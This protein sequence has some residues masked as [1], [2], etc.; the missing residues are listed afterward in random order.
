MAAGLLLAV[1]A[2]FMLPM[3]V[4]ESCTLATRDGFVRD[5]Y[6]LEFFSQGRGPHSST[7]I[8]GHLVSTGERYVTQRVHIVGLKRLVSLAREHALEGHRVPVRYLP[9]SGFWFAVD[10][11]DQ[12]RVQSLE[13]FDQ[14]FPAG[15][16]LANLV[17]AALGIALIRRGAGGRAMGL[18]PSG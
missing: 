7:W 3:S 4:R 15:L 12:F 13:E 16:V 2:L 9:A 14:G 18:P 11:V 17:I 1:A 6:E 10:K 8:E 5:E